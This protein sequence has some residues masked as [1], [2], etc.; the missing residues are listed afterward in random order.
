MAR[1]TQAEGRASGQIAPVAGGS[2]EPAIEERRS[3]SG[4]RRI[5]FVCQRGSAPAS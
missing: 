4:R 5:R 2:S 1:H 3:P